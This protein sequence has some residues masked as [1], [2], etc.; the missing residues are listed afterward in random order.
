MQSECSSFSSVFNILFCT[1]HLQHAVALLFYGSLTADAK[2]AELLFW[3]KDQMRKSVYWEMG[4]WEMKGCGVCED[5]SVSPGPRGQTLQ[6]L[7]G[8][9]YETGGPLDRQ[10]TP[11]TALIDPWMNECLWCAEKTNSLCCVIRLKYHRRVLSFSC[12]LWDEPSNNLQNTDWTNI[13]Y[14]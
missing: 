12:L 9:C 7:S 11:Q 13:S 10:N 4:L 3:T 8:V 1:C 5:G 6:T 14:S 2:L